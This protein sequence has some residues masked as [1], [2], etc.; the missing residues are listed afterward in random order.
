MDRVFN[1]DARDRNRSPW[2]GIFQV[3]IADR[4]I[5]AEQ[6]DQEI[7]RLREGFGQF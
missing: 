2:P 3:E 7:R 4:A 5:K 1:A 6:S